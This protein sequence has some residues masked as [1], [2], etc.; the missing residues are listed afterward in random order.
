VKCNGCSFTYIGESKRSW[1]SRGVEHD[2]G[3]ASNKESAIKQ[4][5]ETTDHDIHPRD[6]QI[7]EHGVSN[8]GKR[9]FLESWHSTMDSDAVNARK[10]FPRA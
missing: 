5:A 1:T 3:Y 10:A 4:H 7:L 9:L 6:A 8:Y 2:P